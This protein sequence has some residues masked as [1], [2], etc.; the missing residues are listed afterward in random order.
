MQKTGLCATVFLARSGL[1]LLTEFNYNHTMIIDII[2]SFF[3]S[4]FLHAWRQQQRARAL[5]FPLFL[6]SDPVCVVMRTDL[7]SCWLL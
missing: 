1:P 7:F 3:G 5:L 4:C 6:I 2:S